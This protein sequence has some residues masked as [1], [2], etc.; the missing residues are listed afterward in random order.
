MD[1]DNIVIYSL[2]R[3]HIL[4]KLK[5]FNF[6]LC[7]TCDALFWEEARRNQQTLKGAHGNK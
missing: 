6:S 5:K 3:K 1:T 2:C 7:Y 4:L